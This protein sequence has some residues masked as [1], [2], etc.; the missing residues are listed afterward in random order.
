[1]QQVLSLAQLRQ[2]GC[3]LQVQRQQARSQEWLSQ[4]QRLLVL[5]LARLRQQVL[6]VLRVQ[7]LVQVGWQWVWRDLR[8]P[9]LLLL[10]WRGWWVLLVWWLLLLGWQGCWG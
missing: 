5:Q 8:A 2:Q 4:G 7:P 6:Q 1:V 3:L 9:Q 10:G